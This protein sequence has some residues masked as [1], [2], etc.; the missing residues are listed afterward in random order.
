M[1]DFG[2]TKF[3]FKYQVYLQYMYQVT[4]DNKTTEQLSGSQESLSNFHQPSGSGGFPKI[5]F[6]KVNHLT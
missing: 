5:N 2:F 4:P 3:I 6:G 1:W